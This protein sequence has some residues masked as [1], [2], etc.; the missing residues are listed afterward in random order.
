MTPDGQKVQGYTAIDPV[1]G[2]IITT[3]AADRHHR[4]ARRAARRRSRRSQFATI[5]NLDAGA[6]VGDTFTTSVQIYDSLGASHVATI[7]YTKTGAGR[8]ELRR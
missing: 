2:K 3:G 8:V 1:T 5:T 7:T 4:A 6:A